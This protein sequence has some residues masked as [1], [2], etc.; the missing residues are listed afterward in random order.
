MAA[1]WKGRA[2]ATEPTRPLWRLL[3]C[4]WR[5]PC[6]ASGAAPAVPVARH[7]RPRLKK[8]PLT[9]SASTSFT[10]SD[11]DVKQQLE[12]AAMRKPFTVKERSETATSTMPTAMGIR[13][14][15]MAFRWEGGRK[16][17][18]KAARE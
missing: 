2:G 12:T 7:G 9:P 15:Q 14:T 11:R 8:Q 18:E 4:Q 10:K 17:E 6:G 13:E 3:R 5:G 16:N 1:A